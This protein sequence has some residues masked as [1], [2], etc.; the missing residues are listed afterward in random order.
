MAG[1]SSMVHS[2]CLRMTESRESLLI[3]LNGYQDAK[4]RIRGSREVRNQRWVSRGILASVGG[5]F[6]MEILFLFG[7]VEV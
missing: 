5:F 3:L 1:V 2:E 7:I 4:P 6:M